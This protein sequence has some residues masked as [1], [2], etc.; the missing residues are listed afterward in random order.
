[1]LQHSH[2]TFTNTRL[3]VLD[4]KHPDGQPQMTFNKYSSD[5]VITS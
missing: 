4:F 5:P 1:M 3:D 2:Q